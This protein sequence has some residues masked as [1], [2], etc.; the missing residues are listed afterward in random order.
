[1]NKINLFHIENYLID[2]SSFSNLLHDKIVHEFEK[3]I[4]DYVGAKYGCSVNSATNAIFLIFLNKGIKI[5]IPSLIPPVVANAILTSGNKLSF[6]DDIDWVGGSYI[7]HDFGDY[8]IIDSAQRLDRNQFSEEANDDDLMFFSF[9]PTK[10]VGSCDGGIIVSNN[11]E[12]IDWFKEAVM[13]GMTNAENNWERKIK[14]PGYKM[15]MNSIQCYIANENLKKLDEKKNK[16]SEIR[17]FYNSFFGINNESS[18]L[19]RLKAK[20]RNELIEIFKKENIVTGIHYEALHLN[21]IYSPEYRT[22]QNSEK[23]TQQTI[24]IP[25]HEKLTIDDCKKICSIIKSYGH[26]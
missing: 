3:N 20:N 23:E 4:C 21:E 26:L 18:H 12:K 14:F 15:Y 5:T 6:N 7:L 24:S 13:N 22:L 25:F 10:P 8:K 1:M 16:L 2:T 17:N 11:K 19:Y 9:Y